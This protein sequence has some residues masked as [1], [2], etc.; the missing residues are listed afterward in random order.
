MFAN[1]F[2]VPSTTYRAGFINKTFILTILLIVYIILWAHARMSV[3]SKTHRTA[4]L[5]AFLPKTYKNVPSTWIIW[6]ADQPINKLGWRDYVGIFHVLRGFAMSAAT[7]SQPLGWQARPPQ[8]PPNPWGA[9]L[10]Q[11]A[12][13]DMIISWSFLGPGALDHILCNILKVLP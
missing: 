1:C 9:V 5:L 10:Y 7:R 4:C 13:V 12:V 3:H 2:Y 11:F 8:N 6:W